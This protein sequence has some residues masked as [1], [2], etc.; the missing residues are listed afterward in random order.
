MSVKN[1]AGKII[2]SDC[3]L[4]NTPWTRLKGLL[5][6]ANF[7][8]GAGLWIRPTKEVHTFFMRFAIDVVFIS[9]SGVVIK[10]CSN[11][12]P[13]RHSG[14]QFKAHQVLELAA[15]EAKRLHIVVG[16]VLELCTGK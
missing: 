14:I 8:S 12:K 16:E 3:E 1:K 11:L 6:R 4:A 10:V 15:G 13:W 7:P 5:G 2:I 9:K